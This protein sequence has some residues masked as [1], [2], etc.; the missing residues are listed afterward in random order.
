ME[1]AICIARSETRRPWLGGPPSA[2]SLPL[3]IAAA[4]VAR[5]T[6]PRLAKAQA[7][8]DISSVKPNTKASGPRCSWFAISLPL[9]TDQQRRHRGGQIQRS[10]AGNEREHQRF[11]D[12]LS[13]HARP[14]GA[15]R[16][17]DGDF[18]PPRD[19]LGEDE[20]A[21]IRAGEQHHEKEREQHERLRR[22]PAADVLV[23]RR[24]R[25]RI[26][27]Q[28]TGRFHRQRASGTDG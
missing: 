15:E 17:P 23:I 1:S 4:R 8:I 6:G 21:R 26:R 10:R 13:S 5:S 19:G 16:Q 24:E 18:V 27:H 28:Q 22:Q 12:Q 20:V 7:T 3:P 14:A 11:R 9:Q 25:P 2:L